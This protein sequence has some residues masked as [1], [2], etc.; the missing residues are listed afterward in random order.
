MTE[1]LKSARQAGQSD[2]R[3]N[4]YFEE[5]E[6]NR[7]SENY[8][9]YRTVGLFTGGLVEGKVID[10]GCGSRI[11][12]DTKRI[13]S[14]T[15]LDISEKLLKTLSF[16]Y[17]DVPPQVN[18]LVQSCDNLPFPD[19]SFDTVCA[20]FVLHH[21][22][23]Q[24]R[25]VS[26]EIVLNAMKQATRVLTDDGRLIIAEVHPR[27]ILR[28]YRWIFPMLYQI[29]KKWLRIELPYFWT[30][31]EMIELGRD[32]GMSK[33]QFVSIPVREPMKL[34]IFH[35]E[36]SSWMIE[37]FQEMNIYVFSR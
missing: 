2:T 27:L 28:P 4:A 34:P 21:L 26:R 32:A 8:E 31:S 9:L 7:F 36:L 5:W 18:T 17:G 1:S 37:S 3:S 10:I 29:F 35:L 16:I 22:A 13:Q 6:D 11:Y 12:Y 15:G 30:R 19:K 33:C 25:E 20:I 24:S 14:W 23:R